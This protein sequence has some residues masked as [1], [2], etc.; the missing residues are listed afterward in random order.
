MSHAVEHYMDLGDQD[1]PK[2]LTRFLEAQYS[3]NKACRLA[4]DIDCDPRTAKNILDRHWPSARHMRAIVRR[5]GRDVLDAVF[6]PEIEPVL[7][8]LTAEERALEEKLELAR[9]R[10]RQVQGGAYRPSLVVA[11]DD[12]D[13]TAQ[14]GRL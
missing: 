4:C 12:A 14:R 8:R 3:D 11:P 1:L 7:A 10:R 13:V 9:A 2:R 5:F 6:A